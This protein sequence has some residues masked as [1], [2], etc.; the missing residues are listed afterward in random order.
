MLGPGLTAIKPSR[1]TPHEHDLTDWS[2]WSFGQIALE[3]V[4]DAGLTRRLTERRG[5]L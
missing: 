1:L 4:R 3:L 5:K 2:R